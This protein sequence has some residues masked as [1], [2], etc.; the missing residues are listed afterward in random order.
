MFSE[1]DVSLTFLCVQFST[2]R[3]EGDS[4]PPALRTLA[5]W[6]LGYWEDPH[7]QHRGHLS[8]N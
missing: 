5:P 7:K 6:E 3:A 4:H 1:P 8:R 2:G